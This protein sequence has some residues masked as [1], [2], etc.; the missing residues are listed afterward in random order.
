MAVCIFRVV[1][2]RVR[3]QSTYVPEWETLKQIINIK[4]L[5]AIIDLYSYLIIKGEWMALFK[6]EQNR[7][8]NIPWKVCNSIE[9]MPIKRLAQTKLFLKIV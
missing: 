1:I 4:I 8:C 5:L 3:I 7:I 9:L 2:N 6:G